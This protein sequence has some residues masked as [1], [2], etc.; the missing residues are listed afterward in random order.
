MKKYPYDIV[1]VINTFSGITYQLYI[2][3]E[4]FL[5]LHE[6][7]NHIIEKHIPILRECDYLSKERL[8]KYAHYYIKRHAKEIHPD[9]IKYFFIEL[10]VF[11]H[12]PKYE[13]VEKILMFYKIKHDI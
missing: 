7:N 4:H 12:T 5:T 11:E 10:S 13:E 9:H 6:S 8:Q 2:M 3:G 1:K